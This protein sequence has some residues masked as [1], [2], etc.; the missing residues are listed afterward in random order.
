MQA[1]LKKFPT[2]A[3]LKIWK[4]FYL[5]EKLCSNILANPIGGSLATEQKFRKIKEKNFNLF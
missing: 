3:E 2:I 4:L 5:P 1:L